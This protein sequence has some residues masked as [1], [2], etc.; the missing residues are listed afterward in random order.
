MPIPSIPTIPS[1]PKI[2]MP[3]PGVAP[4]NPP[5]MP[6]PPKAPQAA[7]PSDIKAPNLPK[8]PVAPPSLP[9]A[10]GVPTLPTPNAMPKLPQVDS[11][12]PTLPKVPDSDKQEN[13]I[14]K[15]EALKETVGNIQEAAKNK[16][17]TQEVPKAKEEVQEVQEVQ[18]AS[19]EIKSEEA[20]EPTTKKR[21]RKTKKE[22]AAAQENQNKQEADTNKNAPKENKA[23]VSQNP[24]EEYITVQL[25]P[26][27]KDF[28]TM[29]DAICNTFNDPEWEKLK[30]E[31]TEANNKIIIETDMN[32]TTLKATVSDLSKLRNKILSPFYK[33][34]TNFQ[35]L[36]SDKPEGILER[37]KRLNSKGSND[38]ERRRS[39]IIA[40]MQYEMNGQLINLYELLEQ[41]RERYNFLKSIMESIEYK[42]KALITMNSAIL[43]EQKLEN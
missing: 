6:M 41:T 10:P 5:K 2:P 23:S 19:A 22:T 33:Y 32:A 40:C 43:M 1:I 30:E 8:T 31:L 18:E 25:K 28:K 42:T 37:V 27:C 34:Q 17:E 39:G 13:A 21:G 16:E 36:V 26:T 15:L 3:T 7:V 12:L 9:K 20:P 29:E 4:N 24:T 11:T 38:Y 35:N 14:T